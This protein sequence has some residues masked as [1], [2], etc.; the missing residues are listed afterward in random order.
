MSCINVRYIV[1]IWQ[2]FAEWGNKWSR[3]HWFILC[4]RN[5]EIFV[6]FLLKPTDCVL[7]VACHSW[8]R[9]S[10]TLLYHLPV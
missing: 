1:S 9:Q 3:P 5:E 4:Q 10:G 6:V 7:G 2:T 8:E